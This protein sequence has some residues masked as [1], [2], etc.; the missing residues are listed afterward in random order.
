MEEKLALIDSHA[1]LDFPEFDEDREEVIARAFSAGVEAIINVGADLSSSRA[2]LSLAQRYG[3][4]YAAVGVHPHEAKTLNQEALAGLRALAE[5]PKV[6]AIGEIGLDYYRNLSPR[7]VQLRAFEEQL[8][9]ASELKKPVIIHDRDAHKDVMDT[10]S[11]WMAKGK[12]A[13]GVLHCFSGDLGMARKALEWG[14]YISFAGPVTFT[15]AR[16]LAEI[17]RELPL[18]K[19]LIETDCPYLAPHPHRGR[20]NEPA[21]LKLVAQAIATL[22]GESLEEVARRT[23][24]NA[25]TLFNM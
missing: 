11:R 2:A 25:R 5:S 4:I 12:L 9:L 7:D 19:I 1:H 15:N 10:L 16:R 13:G 8:A 22:R 20:R 24:A 21:Y 3:P 6:V 14:F 18:D 17:A 23:A